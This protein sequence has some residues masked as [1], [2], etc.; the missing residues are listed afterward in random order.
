MLDP[1][2]TLIAL[3]HVLRVVAYRPLV[4]ALV[5]QVGGEVPKSLVLTLSQDSALPFAAPLHARPGASGL[6]GAA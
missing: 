5:V 6:C 2:L 1:G 4:D 3:S